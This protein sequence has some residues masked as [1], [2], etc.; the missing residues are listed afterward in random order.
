MYLQHMF[1]V[2]ESYICRER[3]PNLPQQLDDQVSVSMLTAVSCWRAASMLNVCLPFTALP[4]TAANLTL[5]SAHG[6]M[7]DGKGRLYLM[8]TGLVFTYCV[9]YFCQQKASDNY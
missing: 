9:L 5:S 6:G 4:F 8:Q 2:V 3:V 7:S 1:T